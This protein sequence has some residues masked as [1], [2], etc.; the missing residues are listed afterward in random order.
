MPVRDYYQ[1]LG[2]AREA[3][4]DELRRAYRRL[5]RRYHPD[6]CTEPEAEQRFREVTEAYE[7]LKNPEKRAA[8]DRR[9][10]G[11][12]GESNFWSS[13]GRPESFSSRGERF[14]AGDAEN[15]SDFFDGL[16][17]G[18]FRSARNPRGWRRTLSRRG[19][20]LQA[21]I[22]VDLEDSF[23]GATRTLTLEVPEVDATGR[24]YRRAR[25]VQIRI[26]K[27]VVAGQQIRLEG[28]GGPPVGRDAFGDLYLEVSFRPH[29]HFEVDGKDLYL[30]LP[31]APWE[32]APG[33]KVKVPT[34]GGMVKLQVPA[35]AASGTELRLGGRGLPCDP[36][37]H[38]YVVLQIVL[39][40]ADS[41]RAKQLYR[42]MARE[43]DFNPRSALGV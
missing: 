3:S 37:G 2:V 27:G 32:A 43:L 35:G 23:H 21:R 19:E 22:L 11:W 33:A 9:G 40:P 20:D 26:P 14:T 24:E 7:V 5:S 1:I 30:S 15:F 17:G 6:I 25:E 31:V 16:F 8:Y 41:R 28:C 39:P 12:R 18:P 4:Q 36:P 29:P 34:P 13:P 42:R 38:L 10:A